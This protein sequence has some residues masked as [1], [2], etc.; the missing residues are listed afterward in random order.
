M[1]QLIRK[2]GQV[3]ELQAESVNFSVTRSASVWSPP[4][5]GV[6]LG[7][8]TNSAMVGITVTGILTDD[9]SVSGSAGASV[10]FDLSRSTTIASNWFSQ[11]SAIG[12]TNMQMII[13][14]LH[15]KEI[16][17]QSCGQNT[18]GLGENISLR[19]YSTGSVPSPTVATKSIIPVNLTGTVNHTGDILTAMNTAMNAA[20]VKV[21]TATVTIPTL[22]TITLGAGTSETSAMSQGYPT[23]S[24][25]K[26]TLTNKVV[27]TDGNTR[28]LVS[29]A[30]GVS[31]TQDWTNPFFTSQ[32]TGGVTGSRKTKGDKVQD[33]LDMTVN[34]S[35]GGGFISPQSFTGDLIEMPDSLGSFDVS[36][37]LRISESESVSKY[38]VGIRIPYESMVTASGV[39]EEVRQFIVPSGPGVSMPSHSNTEVFDPVE[40]DSNGDFSR[41][42]PFMRQGVAIPG[43]VQT[44]EPAYAAGDSVWTYSLGF[45]ACEQLIGV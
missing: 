17:F 2:D 25:E 38:I 16:V 18:A 24:N 20:S 37:L 30:A 6:R 10:I 29:G 35:A 43:I 45:N 32:F 34:V 40:V 33:L 7:F 42:N 27:G 13:A 9:E 36:K 14:A 44:F 5:F 19:F 23:V 3:I 31:S 28:V 12:H 22:F 41:P 8:D 15:G 39:T 11:Q 21:N 26:M 4:I 1:I